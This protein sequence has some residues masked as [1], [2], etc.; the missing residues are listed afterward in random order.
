MKFITQISGK[1]FY[2]VDNV[3]VLKQVRK[4]PT[5]DNKLNEKRYFSRSR[6]YD[7]LKQSLSILCNGMFFNISDSRGQ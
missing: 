1:S 7:D 5:V 4:P 2:F 3:S 6:V